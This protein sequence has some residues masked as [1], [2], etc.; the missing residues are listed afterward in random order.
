MLGVVVGGDSRGAGGVIDERTLQFVGDD[1][2]LVAAHVQQGVDAGLDADAV[3][4][5]DELAVGDEVE[6]AG[7][8]DD[9]LRIGGGDVAAD[10][11]HARA[12]VS[13]VFKLAGGVFGTKLDGTRAFAKF[14][15]PLRLISEQAPVVRGSNGVEQIKVRLGVGGRINVAAACV[16][17]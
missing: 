11:D 14:R 10:P 13:C 12:E 16:G 8:R 2:E 9:P 7:V 15:R 17:A 4:S 6:L 1:A 5:G 3:G